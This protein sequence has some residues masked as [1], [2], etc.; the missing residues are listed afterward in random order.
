MGAEPLSPA[1]HDVWLLDDPDPASNPHLEFVLDDT[2]RF[3]GTQRDAG[4]TVFVH[5]V[6]AESRTPTVAA[7]YLARRFGISGADALTR[8]RRALPDADP[9]PAFIRYLEDIEASSEPYRDD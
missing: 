5:C 9:N 7:A 2:A 3:I 1:H 8:V 4:K 6:R